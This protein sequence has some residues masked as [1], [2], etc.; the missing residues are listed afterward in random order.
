MNAV[1]PIAPRRDTPGPQ[2]Y[3]RSFQA[4]WADIDMNG[5]MRH[6]TYMDYATQARMSCFADHGFGLKEFSLHGCGPILTREEVSYLREIKPGEVFRVRVELSGLSDDLKHFAMRS[7]V[8]RGDEARAAIIDILGAWMDMGARRLMP[9]PPS[10]LA[11][12]ADMPRSAD[13]GSISPHRPLPG[14]GAVHGGRDRS[15][16]CRSSGTWNCA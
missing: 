11:A 1:T 13:F 5:H 16:H 4:I 8:V 6:T 3:E 14:R 10:L 2:P 9:A 12:M 15:H 7:T